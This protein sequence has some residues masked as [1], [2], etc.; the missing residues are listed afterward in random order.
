MRRRLYQ[1]GVATAVAVEEVIVRGVPEIKGTF[2][3]VLVALSL[4]APRSPPE[5]H[6]VR[7]VLF[8]VPAKPVT[9]FSPLAHDD[10]CFVV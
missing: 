10:F 7:Q 1:N 6:P 3:A 9:L 8:V 5:N 4:L 2:T